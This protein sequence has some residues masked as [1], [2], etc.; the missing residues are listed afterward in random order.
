MRK[1]GGEGEHVYCEEPFFLKTF[2]ENFS[3]K[4]WQVR[5]FKQCALQSNVTTKLNCVGH[6]VWAV[7]LILEKK[8]VDIIHS[9]GLCC[10]LFSSFRVCS[11]HWC[12][13]RV[14]HSC[15]EKLVWSDEGVKKKT[16]TEISCLKQRIATYFHR[17]RRIFEIIIWAKLGHQKRNSETKLDLKVKWEVTMVIIIITKVT[18]GVSILEPEKR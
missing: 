4:I 8:K 3:S 9:L 16:H 17:E 7:F 15:R 12:S 6:F 11:P 5:K 2:W 1:V 10:D 14:G 13:H 18:W